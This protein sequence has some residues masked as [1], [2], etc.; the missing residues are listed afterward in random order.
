[1]KTTFK[2]I[3]LTLIVAIAG[4]TLLI[5]LRGR[6][7]SSTVTKEENALNQPKAGRSTASANQNPSTVDFDI[8]TYQKK[9]IQE[10]PDSLRKVYNN[11]GSQPLSDDTALIHKRVKFWKGRSDNLLAGY[12]QQNLAEKASSSQAWTRAGNLYQKAQKAVTDSN[13]KKAAVERS[14]K[15]FQIAL[16]KSP[17]NLE[18]KAGLALTYVEGKQKVM[19]GVGLL[20]EIIEVKPDHRK[21]LFYLGMLSIRSGQ[22]E[23]ALK[24]FQKLVEIQPKNPFNHLYLG[25]VQEQLGNKDVALREYRK[26]QKLVEQPKLK[27]NAEEKIKDLKASQKN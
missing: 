13:L 2:V 14:L 6:E 20:K 3:Q 16:N 9:R 27:A 26:Y 7:N 1:M 11:L 12:F 17:E 24:R 21:A 8:K 25:N 15:C 5:F 10:L 19:K 4:L 18:A 23:K 22:Y